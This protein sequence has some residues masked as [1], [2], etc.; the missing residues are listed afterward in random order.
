MASRLVSDLHPLILPLYH[1]FDT[2]M[3]K[4]G[5]DYIITCT[6]RSNEEQAKLYAK[7]R[8]DFG[9]IVTN[10]R[11]GES[12]HNVTRNG[13]PAACAFDIAVF[14]NGKLNWSAN[15]PDWKA[16]GEIGLI[17]GL[18]WAGVWKSFREFPHFQ[19]ANWRNVK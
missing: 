11:P 2:E 16:A 7:G 12:A 14:E 13:M 19:L 8:S 9:R 3:K 4:K 1:A 17:V 6:Y 10:A 5:I 15:D 18:D